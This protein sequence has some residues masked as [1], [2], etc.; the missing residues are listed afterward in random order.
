MHQF[1]NAKKRLRQM[2]PLCIFALLPLDALAAETSTTI[3]LVWPE[4]TPGALGSR[5]VDTPTLTPFLASPETATGAAIVVCPGGGYAGL[6]PSEGQDYARWLNELGISAFVLKYRLGSAGYHHPAMLNDAARALRTVRSRATEW[7]LDPARI[8]II[9]SSAGGHLASTLLTHFDAGD[10]SSTDTVEQVSSRPDLGILCYPVITMDK[11]FTHAGSRRNLLGDDPSDALVHLLSNNEQVTSA[12][13]PTFIFHT[14]DDAAVPVEN[15]LMFAT[16][17]ARTDVRFELHVYPSGK[18]GMG[19]GSFHKWD[20]EHRH[21]W[22][23]AAAEWLKSL[24][25]AK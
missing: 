8:G 24:N 16:G 22:T 19:L 21:P 17:L 14:A 11:K 4:G 5:D 25:F 20:P 1:V 13:P 9:G 15:A 2:L 7:H 18:H 10:P 6:A 3:M 12:T 23:K